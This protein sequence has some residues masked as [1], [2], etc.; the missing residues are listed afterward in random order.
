MS[1]AQFCK[2]KAVFAVAVG[3]LVEV[4]EIHVDLIIGKLLVC[5]GVEMKKGLSEFLKALDPHFGGREG[6]HPGDD[7]YA[8]VVAHGS[9]DVTYADLGCLHSGEQLD[10]DRSF[11]FFVQKINHLSAVFGDLL[12]T[13]FTIKVLA[14]GDKI[15]LFHYNPFLLIDDI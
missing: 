3:C 9:P 10:A 11:Q 8:V 14:S 15:Q 6:V 12:Q 2:D 13:L 1:D 5:L 7:A 4:H